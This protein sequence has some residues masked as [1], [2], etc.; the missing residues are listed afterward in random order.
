MRE[1]INSY[2]KLISNTPINQATIKNRIL[3][4]FLKG[5][6][7]SEYLGNLS[8]ADLE[9]KLT[10]LVEDKKTEIEDMK[11]INKMI[12]KALANNLTTGFFELT[13]PEVLDLLVFISSK[14]TDNDR[15]E[16][17]EDAA[18]FLKSAF[19]MP[20]LNTLE[21][22]MLKELKD[23]LNF[24]SVTV[25]L[26]LAEQT[27]A[28]ISVKG[29]VFETVNA[30][31]SFEMQTSFL[32]EKIITIRQNMEKMNEVAKKLKIL[33]DK[34]DPI[35]PLISVVC[36]DRYDADCRKRQSE[37]QELFMKIVV[38]TQLVGENI[39]NPQIA[40]ES[41]ILLNLINQ[42][43]TLTREQLDVFRTMVRS[44]EGDV[45]I[46][47]SQIALL[48]STLL[49]IDGA[50]TFDDTT[51]DDRLTKI[52]ENDF[53][54]RTST[55]S[56][57]LTNLFQIND[58]MDEVVKCIE[59]IEAVPESEGS[60][61][62]V[63]LKDLIDQVP[64]LASKARPP[65]RQIQQIS[66][67]I[68]RECSDL[69]NLQMSPGDLKSLKFI[70][71]PLVTFEQM[72]TSQILVF[73][74]KLATITGRTVTAANLEVEM[75]AN[76]GE[77][78]V[79]LNAINATVGRQ[80]TS[81]KE[82]YIQ[83]YQLMKSTLYTLDLVMQKINRVLSVTEDDEEPIGYGYGFRNSLV[84]S[85][86]KFALRVVHYV[87][88]SLF[89]GV[90]TEGKIAAAQEIFQAQVTT[91]TST[92]EKIILNKALSTI[93]SLKMTILTE[94]VNSKIQ[95]ITALEENQESISDLIF[96]IQTFDSSGN[97]VNIEETE[98]SIPV[99][100][101]PSEVAL[102]RNTRNMLSSVQNF[103]NET[104]YQAGNPDIMR[105]RIIALSDISQERFMPEVTSFTLQMGKNF[106]AGAL[107]DLGSQ[108]LNYRL[109]ELSGAAINK[110]NYIIF[111]IQNYRILISEEIL[112]LYSELGGAYQ[113][114]PATTT[115]SAPSL[116][117]ID[118]TTLG[119]N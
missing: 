57:Q 5:E 23:F 16:A 38:M 80:A 71:N 29:F 27:E 25:S 78:E 6:E 43:N 44:I 11:L 89:E 116:P 114:C 73:S 101:I 31:M 4:S 103:L 15:D 74:Q 98:P 97:I 36:F 35:P 12:D 7:Q 24:L 106:R 94:I 88:H 40:V 30:S 46:Y 92:L 8:A 33:V 110:L 75:I 60:E 79:P 85:P 83:R 64:M 48:E 87:S 32:N 81:N 95:L 118:P 18:F 42:I 21:K 66:V 55:L 13:V 70:E 39:E 99:A 62:S 58:A 37:A 59:K 2:P 1:Y 34:A 28:L 50:L 51:L 100:E 76:S 19:R 84:I 109:S 52:E 20:A 111:V 26:R 61:E 115:L 53:E 96:N 77:L 54:Q 91:E 86:K 22:K 65:V 112:D 17:Y 107:L 68:N 102:I 41:E 63:Y 105:S 10:E 119:E 82:V 47:V 90:I 93:T 104:I 67:E 72:F 113:P 9:I 108:L 56:A 49:E 45:L 117:T 14:I 3:K 69:T